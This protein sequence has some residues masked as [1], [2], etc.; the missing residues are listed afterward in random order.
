[1]LSNELR[2]G[3]FRSKH[4]PLWPCCLRQAGAYFWNSP[5]PQELHYTFNP[6]SNQK[7]SD[8]GKHRL[9]VGCNPSIIRH[10]IHQCIIH[11]KPVTTEPPLN[12][13]G[14]TLLTY[15]VN[16]CWVVL[17]KVKREE[18]RTDDTIF[19]KNSK[20][21]YTLVSSQIIIKMRIVCFQ[22][23]FN[24]KANSHLIYI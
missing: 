3:S 16:Q 14:S 20:F 22:T 7:R 6:E 4:A 15:P 9:F 24:N 8:K 17:I 1:M 18:T 10:S 13:Q 23:D 5:T 19:L 11:W 12:H 21:Y 2:G